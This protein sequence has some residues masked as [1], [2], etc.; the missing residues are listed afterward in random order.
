ML[1][2]GATATSIGN[3]TGLLHAVLPFGAIELIALPFGQDFEVA[4]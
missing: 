4:F 3:T 1:V 2:F